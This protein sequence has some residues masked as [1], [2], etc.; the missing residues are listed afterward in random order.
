MK[1][2][3]LIPKI[4]ILIEAEKPQSQSE[5][6]LGLFTDINEIRQSIDGLE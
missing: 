3:F 6:D 1:F 2:D 5:P 4:Q